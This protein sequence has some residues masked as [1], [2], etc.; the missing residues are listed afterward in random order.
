MYHEA[1]ATDAALEQYSAALACSG[2]GRPAHAALLNRG[3]ALVEKGKVVDGIADFTALLVNTATEA[4]FLRNDV[5]LLF[6]PI[7]PPYSLLRF[8]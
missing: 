6:A 7:L 2:S 5:L 3:I 8:A 1:G 4:S